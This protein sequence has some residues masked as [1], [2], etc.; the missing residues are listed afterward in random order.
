MHAALLP[1][2]QI[3]IQDPFEEG[4]NVLLYSISQELDPVFAEKCTVP[5]IHVLSCL[6]IQAAMDSYLF[7]LSLSPAMLFFV[8]GACTFG[9]VPCL[10][11]C[12]RCF[13]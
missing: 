9:T 8:A 13:R 11:S 3:V 7:H 12:L 10:T 1:N 5:M 2:P 6:L 4:H